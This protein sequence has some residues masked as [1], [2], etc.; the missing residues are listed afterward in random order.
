MSDG[1]HEAWRAV[2]DARLIDRCEQHGRDSERLRRVPSLPTFAREPKLHLDPA[3]WGAG[4]LA[5]HERDLPPALHEDLHQLMPQAL[6]RDLYRPVPKLAW[7]ERAIVEGSDRGYLGAMRE[8]RAARQRPELP[9]VEP[10]VRTVRA[11]QIWRRALLA[12]RWQ[13]LLA[14]DEPRRPG[15]I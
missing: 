10:A 5:V 7:V 6:L 9:R 2:V 3:A 13:P 4:Y 1:G 12:E 8:A 14:D 15:A 11:H